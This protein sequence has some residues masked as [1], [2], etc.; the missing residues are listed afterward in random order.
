MLRKSRCCVAWATYFD[1]SGVN[2]IS[3]VSQFSPMH[4]PPDQTRIQV[5]RYFLLHNL[6]AAHL[7]VQTNFY[8]KIVNTISMQRPLH[9]PSSGSLFL[10][11]YFVPPTRTVME[12]S[13]QAPAFQSCLFLQTDSQY[14]FHIGPTGS[15]FCPYLISA[16]I[17]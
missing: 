11:F 12:K 8:V 14:D 15:I 6:T 1:H 16:T 10:F 13:V 9:R 4:Q 3:S 7:Q 5:R 2:M 17:W